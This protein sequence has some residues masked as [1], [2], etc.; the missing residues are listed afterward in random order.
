MGSSGHPLDIAETTFTPDPCPPILY[1]VFVFFFFLARS[2]P[3]FIR[4]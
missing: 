1:L 3:P 4:L 2:F